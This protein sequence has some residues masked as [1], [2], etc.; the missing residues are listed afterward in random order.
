MISTLKM[1]YN[2]VINLKK[3]YLWVMNN[4]FMSGLIFLIGILRNIMI[5]L[6]LD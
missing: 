1:K 5:V 2:N 4:K 6:V 3:K